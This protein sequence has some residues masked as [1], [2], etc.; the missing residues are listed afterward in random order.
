MAGLAACLCQ[1]EE[2]VESLVASRELWGIQAEVEK[3]LVRSRETKGGINRVAD[4]C[5]IVDVFKDEVE[6]FD[7]ETGGVRHHGG[8]E[9]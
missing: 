9:V 7:R 4:W 6:E 3:V 1:V 5:V 8:C 2:P